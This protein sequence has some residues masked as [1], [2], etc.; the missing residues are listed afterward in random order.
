MTDP[1]ILDAI[2]VSQRQFRDIA[3]RIE[4]DLIDECPKKTGALS[5]S[6]TKEKK[7]DTLYR[8]GVD[9]TL[10]RNN[11]KN[12]S[13]FDYSEI[14]V[15]GLDHWITIKVKNKKSLHWTKNGKDYFAYSVRIPP[16]KGNDF[17]SRVADKYR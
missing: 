6:I 12:I 13:H 4:N 16:R 15:D 3:T 8:I 9:S 14:V 7:S 1:I 10:L 17:I 2:K 5:E 11:P